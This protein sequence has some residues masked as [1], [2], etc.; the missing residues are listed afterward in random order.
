MN[1]IGLTGGIATGKST[2]ARLVEGRGIPVVDADHVS[3]ELSQP[4]QSGYEAIVSHF[5]ASILD[6]QKLIDRQ[7]LAL[8]IFSD[9]THKASLEGILHPLIQVEV[10]RRRTDLSQKGHQLCFY[11]VP[12]LFEKNLEQQFSSTVFVWCSPAQ[13]LSRLMARNGLTQ[14]Q[15]VLRISNQMSLL[16]KVSRANHCLDN[17][18][19]TADIEKQLDVLLARLTPA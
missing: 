6:A 14:E 4:G 8:L 18:G 16:D 5:G 10:K 3:H 9:A 17:S 12:L 13:Q 1:W 15:A 2:V 7:K 11:D 19:D